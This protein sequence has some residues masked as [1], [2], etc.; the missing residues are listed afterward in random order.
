LL[1]FVFG[2]LSGFLKGP[3]LC[4][5]IQAAKDR[6]AFLFFQPGV[7]EDSPSILKLFSPAPEKKCPEILDGP[8]FPKTALPALVSAVQLCFYFLTLTLFPLPYKNILSLRKAL[9]SGL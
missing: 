6:P 2:D 3:G 8:P 4:P 5:H 9:C 7:R 1:P